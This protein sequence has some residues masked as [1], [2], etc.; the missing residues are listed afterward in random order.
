VQ[1]QNNQTTKKIIHIDMDA[2]YASVEQRDDSKLRGKPLAVGGVSGRGVIAAASYEARVF[3]VRSAM[4][5]R[6]ALKLCPELLI[7]KPNFK[8]YKEVSQEIHRIFESYTDIIEPLSLDEAFLDVTHCN[9]A[10]NSATLIAKAIKHEIKVNL[11]L[12]ASA[13]VSY[14]K[15]LAKI[16][17]DQDKPDGLFVIEPAF[18]LEFI[19]SLAID[20]FFG[21]G[22]VTADKLNA[23]G[24]FKGEDLLDYSV[25]ELEMIVGKQARFFY[26]IARGI[27]HREVNSDRQR[28]S[29]GAEQTF[30]D[31]LQEAY[32]IH[33]K[34][35][36]VFD[37]LWKRYKANDLKGRT[38]VLKYR[39]AN[40][41]TY[42]RSITFENWIVNQ[43]ALRLKAIDMIKDNIETMQP[44][45]L[46]GF[47]ITNLQQ[48]SESQQL[49]MKL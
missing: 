27:D 44:I 16:A 49:V 36:L 46:I 24:I 48:D 33:E 47:S 42:T 13:G 31:G 32:L 25:T 34:S 21:V 30:G 40:F 45:R 3:G 41:E 20:K 22:S 6:K 14:N 29:V 18:G 2:F 37:E 28:K 19:K 4:P 7:V 9:I 39:Y 10:C 8:K 11:N 12:V 23:K 35:M 1:S 26:Q 43:K 17:S 38:F 5:V 15:F